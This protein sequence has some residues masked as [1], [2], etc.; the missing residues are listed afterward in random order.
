MYRNDELIATIGPGTSYSDTGVPARDHEYVVRAEDAA[1]NLSDPSNAASVVV[2]DTES[3]TSPGNLAASAVDGGPVLLEWEA[4]SDNV[5]V[6]EYEVYR[7][8]QL[9][10]TIEPATSYSDAVGPGSYAYYLKALDPAGNSSDESNTANVTV[11]EP[12]TENPGPPGNLRAQAGAGKVDLEWDAATDNRAVTKYEIRRD[13]NLVA[14]VGAVTSWSDTT[15]PHQTPTSTT[16]ARSTRPTTCRIRATPRARRCPTRRSRA[17]PTNL[18]RDRHREPGRPHLGCGERQR[19][20]HAATGSIATA[21]AIAT[22]GP[23]TSYAD[24]SVTAPGYD[25]EVR[26]LDAADNLSDPSNTVTATVP[27]A[28]KPTAPGNLA[29]SA[30][31]PEPGQ[32]HLDGVK[33]Q[34]RRDRLPGLP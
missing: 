15:W 4:A 11:L 12:D 22:V 25:Y 18:T 13:G 30:A 20:G 7:D 6:A 19:G 16:C 27:D 23:V 32:P 21:R 17:A 5:G 31:G 33:R 9:I 2:P 14:T 29:A 10:D 3:P 24:T 8:D 26:A 1:G 34:H 28:Q